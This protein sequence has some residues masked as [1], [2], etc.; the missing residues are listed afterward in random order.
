MNSA[1]QGEHEQILTLVVNPRSHIALEEPQL[2]HCAVKAPVQYDAS[3]RRVRQA[4]GAEAQYPQV[5]AFLEHGPCTCSAVT[6]IAMLGYHG[7]RL[8]E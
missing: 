7:F 8:R 1:K 3:R 6:R 5:H 2:L 4:F